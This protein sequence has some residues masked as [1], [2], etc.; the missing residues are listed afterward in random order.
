M[1]LF[2]A[3][4]WLFTLLG[5]TIL[6]R[7]GSSAWNEY[8][9]LQHAAHAKGRVIRVRYTPGSNRGSGGAYPIVE[10]APA[11]GKTT[12]FE[13]DTSFTGIGEGDEVPVLY[14]PEHPRQAEI[15]GFSCQWGGILTAGI[16]GA[17][18]TAG[19]LPCVLYM[20]VK[21]RRIRW[22]KR[23]GQVFTAR[24]AGVQE[25]RRQTVNGKHPFRIQAEWLDPAGGLR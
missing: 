5:L 20:L 15:E 25:D 7:A 19:G 8:T 10:F 9:F 23:H 16:I 14:L 21:R 18:F 22:L 2:R 17:I 1:G 12:R 13:S 4:A 24:V 3:L 11:Q 6:G